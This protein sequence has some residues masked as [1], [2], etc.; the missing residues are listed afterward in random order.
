MSQSIAVHCPACGREHRYT[1]PSYPCMCGTAVSPPLD[2]RGAVRPVTHRVWDEEWVPARCDGCGRVGIWPR[3]D[4]GCPCGTTLR[5]PV[6]E[7]PP[8][9]CGPGARPAFHPVTIRTAKDAVTT[10]VLY[11]NWLGYDGVRRADQHPPAGI[12]LIAPGVMAQVDPTVHPASL[13]DVECLWLT[14]MTE[15]ASC[16]YFT[17]AGYEE[18]ARTRAESLG[19]PLY[20]LDLTGTPQ[21]VNTV[22]EQLTATGAP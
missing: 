18:R 3:P 13:R 7:E 1:P 20:V 17:L 4:L 15:A 14:A 12:G 9:G 22:A 19:M 16:V 11:L 6:A 21:P 5:L 8:A 2:P 10:A